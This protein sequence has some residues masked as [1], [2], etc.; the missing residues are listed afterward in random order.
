MIPPHMLIMLLSFAFG[1][2]TTT[3]SGTVVDASD[4]PLGGVVVRTE[5][6]PECSTTTNDA[7][8][9]TL[10]CAP[11]DL[12]VLFEHPDH[13]S[14]VRTTALTPNDSVELTR[15]TMHA[16]PTETGLHILVN[17]RFEPLP[18][19]SLKRTTINNGSAKQRAFCVDSETASPFAAGRAGTVTMLANVPQNWRAFR[20]DE[21][22]CAYR[23][24]KTAEGHW[25]IDHQERPALHA[26]RKQTGVV[27]TNWDAAGGDYFLADW[28]G[29]FVPVAS[30]TDTYSGRWIRFD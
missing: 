12:T 7:G 8:T 18:S 4:M 27:L 29:F 22:G 21:H 17:N 9:F 10:E 19:A 15:T 11:G 23:D 1:C 14:V 24:A 26:D 30:E 16:I 25:V 3:L 2:S 20:M 5:A 28:A 6:N 13:L